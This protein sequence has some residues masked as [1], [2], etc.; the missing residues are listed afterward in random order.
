MER[1]NE[2]CER[3]DSVLMLYRNIAIMALMTQDA[4]FSLRERERNSG[5]VAKDQKLIEIQTRQFS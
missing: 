5:E 2:I 3:T 1:N 4:K